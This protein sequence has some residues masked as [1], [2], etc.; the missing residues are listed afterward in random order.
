MRKTLA[1]LVT[2]AA[3][4]AAAVA[5]PAPAG[6]GDIVVR[7]IFGPAVDGL[8]IGVVEGS[9]YD[10]DGYVYGPLPYGRYYGPRAYHGPRGHRGSRIHYAAHAHH[11]ARAY[12]V[13][14]PYYGGGPFYQHHY[15]CRYW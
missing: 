14:D 5:A 11:L 13:L 2:V 4:G 10:Y 8:T 6:A 12:R 7:P 15:C 3:V 9:P 1:V